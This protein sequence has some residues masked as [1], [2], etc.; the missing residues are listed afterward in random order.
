MTNRFR[1]ILKCLILFL[2]MILQIHSNAYASDSLYKG[3]VNPPSDARPDVYWWWNN[4]A[5][6]ETEILRELDVLKKAGI[7]GVLIFPMAKT[8]GADDIGVKGL[9]WLS[10][11]WGRMVKIAVEGAKKR[12]MR[13]DLLVGTGWPFGG[14]FL[15]KGEQIQKM[16]VATKELTGPGHFTGSIK[17]L[18]S[19]PNGAYGETDNGLDPQLR[20]LRLLPANQT[21]VQPGIDLMGKVQS[22][23]TVEF[24]IPSGK[25]V[26]YTGTLREGFMIVNI[27]A[28]GGA[29]PVLDHFNKSAT[30]AYLKKFEDSLKPAMGGSLKGLRSL[31]C[32]SLE[33]TGANWTTNLP[34]EFRKRRGYDMEPYLPYM[35]DE[36][37]PEGSPEFVDSIWRLRYDMW[38]TLSELFN[39]EFLLPFHEWCRSNGVDSRVE[40]YGCP[41]TDH[42]D[43]KLVPDHPMC[44]TWISIERNIPPN[45]TLIPLEKTRG[46]ES[47]C[48]WGTMSNKYTSSAAHLTGRR[49]VSCE[50]MTNDLSAF[51]T[52]LE[53]TK[54]AC[55]LNYITGVNHPV[56]HG[57]NYNPLEAGFP[58][59][60][61]CGEYFDERNSWWPYFRK[62]TDYTARLTW[63]FQETEPQAE[64]ALIDPLNHTWEA[65][66]QNGYSA[67]YVSETLL[68]KAVCEKGRLR[69]GKK[70]FNALVIAY[71]WTMEPETAKAIEQ[72]ARDGAKIIF[73]GQLPSRYPG[74]YDHERLDKEIQ[75]AMASALKID[76]SRVGLIPAPVKNASAGW[77][78]KALRKY[79]INPPVE[80]SDPNPLLYQI[81][82]RYGSREIFFFANLDC[83][84][85]ASFNARFTTGSRTP[86]QWDPETGKRSV[87]PYSSDKNNLNIKLNPGE[88]ILL[89]FEL[90]RNAIPVEMPVINEKDHYEIKTP[91]TVTFDPVEGKEFSRNMIEL[92]DLVS[93]T[94]LASFSGSAIYTTEFNL[95]NAGHRML[96]LGDVYDISEVKLNGKPLGVKWW[97][98]HLYDTGT[99]LRKGNNRLEIKVTTTL[100]NYVRS[101]KNNP[102]ARIWTSDKSRKALPSGLAGPVRLYETKPTIT[103]LQE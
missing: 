44:E 70:T 95:P 2:I 76:P 84:H 86:W 3:F 14:P 99:I 41:S 65:L 85:P 21:S 9:D 93:D 71:G 29:G 6:T 10:P 78:R 80:I 102:V 75:T 73:I 79:G 46:P 58:G 19:L 30:S 67:D 7:G 5:L 18:M 20:F 40:A 17:N 89:V 63:I 54:I 82:H 39:E 35:L 49:E 15:K 60:F 61:Y 45:E 53:Q 52:T 94:D 51:R 69:F 8:M 36:S 34:E 12:G 100:S 28:P 62:L 43:S 32:D 48:L 87:Y 25:H 97:G 68:Q 22:D 88:S 4:N 42:V 92:I 1:L 59:W 98:K 27:P 72:L 81:H 66:H 33:F 96:S 16:K 11:E 50:T 91:W 103:G 26:L 101:L 23:G 77:I 90:D 13:A 57:Y 38:K 37:N 31:H 55:D 47:M 64:I 74:F 83:L 56:F 24:D